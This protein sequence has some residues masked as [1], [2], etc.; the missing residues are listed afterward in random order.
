MKIGKKTLDELHACTEGV[1]KFRRYPGLEDG[2]AELGA[3]CRWMVSNGEPGYVFW[4]LP[5]LM[6]PE[7]AVG[8]TITTAKRHC[9]DAA[10]G[11][12]ADGWLSGEDRT[13]KSAEAAWAAARVEWAPWAA[14][15]M[16]ARTAMWVA[17]SAT[18][19]TWEANWAAEYAYAG[20]KDKA[21]EI[22]R[23]I[24]DA[25]KILS[26]DEKEA[27][28]VSDELRRLGIPHSPAQYDGTGTCLTCGKRREH[29]PG[30]HTFEEIQE[31]ARA[32]RPG[33]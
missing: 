17:R 11:K 16:A 26:A 20:V 31:A 25:L 3:L 4:L 18:W 33:K 5:R 15:R 10:W 13:E 30:V 21:A 22:E 7:E 12:W 19:A 27:R 23:Q 24:A 2:R 1:E 8:W 6:T 14:A 9:D 32:Q 28:A 29:C